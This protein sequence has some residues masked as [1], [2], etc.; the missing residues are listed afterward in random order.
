MIHE[1]E[2]TYYFPNPITGKDWYTIG[3]SDVRELIVSKSGGHRLTTK[4]G[5]MIYV[6]SGWICIEIKSDFGWE[7]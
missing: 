1:K 2:R 3:V 6:R 5:R 4:D 7:Q